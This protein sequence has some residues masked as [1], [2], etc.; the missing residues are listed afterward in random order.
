MINA[1]WQFFLE[2]FIRIV[3]DQ[4]NKTG[5]FLVSQTVVEIMILEIFLFELAIII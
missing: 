2:N 5:Y 4:I 1:Q 3:L